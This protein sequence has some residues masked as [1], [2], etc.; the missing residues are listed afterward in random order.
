MENFG[1]R[2]AE[3]FLFLTQ[4][5]FEISQYIICNFRHHIPRSKVSSK[6]HGCAAIFVFCVLLS[7]LLFLFIWV[8]HLKFPTIQISQIKVKLK[9]LTIISHLHL[10]TGFGDFCS[11]TVV[12]RSQRNYRE[13][14]LEY[15]EKMINSFAYY[16]MEL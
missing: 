7:L 13:Y 3:F 1:F 10:Y 11:H 4:K 2:K 14:Y 15:F 6:K 12:L 16:L 5:L 9:G 8:L